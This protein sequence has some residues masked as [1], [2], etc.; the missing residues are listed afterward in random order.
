MPKRPKTRETLEELLQST[1]FD[2]FPDDDG[3]AA[4]RIDSKSAHGHTP[5]HVLLERGNHYG[6]RVLIDEGADINAIGLHGETPLHVAI[7]EGDQEMVGLLLKAGALTD[8]ENAKGETAIDA[9]RNQSGLSPVTI[10]PGR[11]R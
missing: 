11:A 1:S 5:L 6:C 7:W 3:E 8:I 10:H 2:L 4:V 9:T